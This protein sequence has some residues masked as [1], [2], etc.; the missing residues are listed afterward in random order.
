MKE[1]PVVLLV[2]DD[3]FKAGQLAEYLV[4]VLPAA[5]IESARSV[6]SG[7]QALREKPFDLIILDMSLTAY[8]IDRYEPGGTPQIFGGRELLGYAEFVGVKTPA[9]VVTQFE[10]FGKGSSTI[11]ISSLGMLLEDEFPTNYRGILHFSTSSDEWK[12]KLATMIEGL[13]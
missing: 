10:R 3:P 1:S 9:I 6:A 5:A 7:K 13:T 2:E 12:S 11:D 8:D 4:E